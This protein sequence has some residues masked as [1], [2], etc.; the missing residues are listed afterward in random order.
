MLVGT[1]ALIVIARFITAVVVPAVFGGL[2]L[3]VLA[4]VAVQT[5]ASFVG[6]GDGGIRRPPRGP[7]RR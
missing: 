3:A 4:N 5:L 6:G 1:V 2:L 7:G